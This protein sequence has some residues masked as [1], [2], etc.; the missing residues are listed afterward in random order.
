MGAFRRFSGESPLRPG[1]G[2]GFTPMAPEAAVDS[3]FARTTDKLAPADDGLPG[4]LSRAFH[5][6]FF[7]DEAN[8]HTIAR[9]APTRTPDRSRQPDSQEV[10]HAPPQKKD[11]G[12]LYDQLTFADHVTLLGHPVA[13]RHFVRQLIGQDAIAITGKVF[14]T[15][16]QSPEGALRQVVIAANCN[17]RPQ[18]DPDSLKLSEYPH[19]K[20]SDMGIFGSGGVAETLPFRHRSRILGQALAGGDADTAATFTDILGSIETA[21]GVPVQNPATG[22]IVGIKTG[23][24]LEQLA[25]AVG[26]Y[27]DARF[28][29]ATVQDEDGV[30]RVYPYPEQPELLSKSQVDRLTNLAANNIRLTVTR[31]QLTKLRERFDAALKHQSIRSTGAAGDYFMDQSEGLVPAIES[32]QPPSQGPLVDIKRPS[33]SP[34]LDDASLAHE[35][36]A[37]GSAILAAIDETGI[38]AAL[39]QS[40]TEIAEV[41]IEGLD[42][43]IRA[44]PALVELIMERCETAEPPIPFRA[45]V[46]DVNEKTV[47]FIRGDKIVVAAGKGLDYQRAAAIVRGLPALPTTDVN[48]ESHSKGA[49]IGSSTGTNTNEGYDPDKVQTNHGTGTNTG[50]SGGG[51]WTY[52]VG[53]QHGVRQPHAHELTEGVPP[54][55]AARWAEDGKFDDVYDMN[56]GGGTKTG[57]VLPGMEKKTPLDERQKI[58]DII[59][60]EERHQNSK[61]GTPPLP[62]KPT[63]DPGWSKSGDVRRMTPQEQTRELPF[64]QGGRNR[65]G[66]VTQEFVNTQIFGEWFFQNI[67][68]DPD[69][70]KKTTPQERERDWYR[71][72]S[73]TDLTERQARA[74]WQNHINFGGSRLPWRRGR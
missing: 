56:R 12:G 74:A 28:G 69:Y 17:S 67:K 9:P 48:S 29:T 43:M 47:P 57:K 66:Q 10:L 30:K 71:W 45:T 33:V 31:A 36:R 64:T 72:V 51:N 44:D 20:V 53:L 55:H 11:T 8:A 54:W 62:P 50:G 22:E 26:V 58:D 1:G 59:S 2:E 4:H 14:E 40:Q 68:K 41:C 27:D 60:R 25:D 32:G 3:G 24:D 5:T 39:G 13:A 63:P 65:W 52:T 21:L 15:A 38:M 70:I 23:V 49:S 19:I 42:K 61:S 73:Q 46:M 34:G 7:D 37:M 16:E 35:V 6:P 18:E